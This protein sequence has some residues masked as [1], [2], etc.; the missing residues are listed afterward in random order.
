MTIWSPSLDEGSGPLYRRIADALCEDVHRGVLQPGSRLPTHRELAHTLNVTVGTVTR[1]YAEAERRGLISGTV[2]RG[3]FVRGAD[4]AAI[5]ITCFPELTP[6]HN[7][8]PLAPPM[9]LPQSS[10]YPLDLSLN[11]PHD[12]PFASVLAAGVAKMTGSMLASVGRYQPSV[13]M[14]SHRQAAQ[15][16]LTQFEVKAETDDILI[17]PGCQGGLTTAFLAL[18]R[19]GDVVLHEELTWPGL[20]AAAL[21]LGLS[22]AAVAMDAEGLLPDALEAACRDH[23]ARVL[24]VM[25]TLHNPT[26]NVLSESRRRAIAAIAQ[27]YDLVIIEDDVYGF[28]L[29][30]RPSP[31]RNFAPKQVIFITSLSKCVAPGLRVGF[32]VAPPSLTG[33]L[34]TALRVN[35]LMTS[36]VAAEV[37]SE[38]IRCGAA[39]ASAEWQ[40]NEARA[41]QAL[42]SEILADL[43]YGSHPAAFHG[44]FEVAPCQPIEDFVAA[45][46]ARGVMV[47]PGT[48]FSGDP[49]PKAAS[50]HVRLCL[51]AIPERPHLAA[52]LQI[53]AAVA[54]GATPPSMPIV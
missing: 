1:A 11:Y 5:E 26:T 27:R 6:A 25:P 15:Q 46:L 4:S 21:S 16:W 52:A 28:L 39:A 14:R 2:G 50:S 10:T 53:V 8:V 32:V 48:A 30:S 9:A 35:V 3:T 41:R 36:S 54:R 38:A 29:D 24:Y 22:T 42:A 7:A 13:G 40:R 31:V 51:C 20:R 17:V 37:A 19:P 43:P 45:L 23:E 12:A 47:T 44:W 18:C 49:T 33:R 34:A